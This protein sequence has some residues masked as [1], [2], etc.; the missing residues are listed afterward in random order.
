M[1]DDQSNFISQEDLD[2]AAK[3]TGQIEELRSK[4]GEVNDKAREM[5]RAIGQSS[6][7]TKET[8]T[9]FTSV[10]NKLVDLIDLNNRIGQSYISQ[11][12]INR[13]VL[14]INSDRVRITKLIEI[15]AKEAKLK[16]TDVAS[17]SER[18]LKTNFRRHTDARN[19]LVL[20]ANELKVTE[21]TDLLLKEI[22][23]RLSKG[24]D[25]YTKMYFKSSAIKK[26]LSDIARI[27][28]IGPLLQF[29]AIGDKM[30]KN[31][32]SGIKEILSQSVS[33]M[34]LPAIQFIAVTAALKSLFTA[35]LQMDKSITSLSNNLAIS[36]ES[37]N[38]L[39]DTFRKTSIEGKVLVD[40][41]DKAFLSV[42]NLANG[43]LELQNSLETNAM[44]TE[45]M[46]QGQIMMTKQM[47]MT[48]EEA[49]GIQKFS[50]LTG[51]SSDAILQSAIKQNNAAI[52]YRKILKEVSS[53]SAEL[54]MR[55]ANDPEQIARA[56][57]QANKLGM[58]LEETRKI[59]SSLLNFEQSIEGELESELLLGR[60]F[61][62]EKARELALMGKSSEAAGELL[63]QI[64]GIN[65]LEKLEKMNV[66]QRERVAAAIG[67]SSDELSKAARE[68][69]VLNKLG[70]Q[71][72][73]ALEERYKLLKESNDLAGIA[74]LQQDAAKVAGGEILLQDIA[75][76]NLNQRF[77][78]SVNRIKDAFT[79]MAMT[80]TK[81]MNLIAK[82]LEHT[83]VLKGLLI[84]S[85][86]AMSAMAVSATITSFGAAAAAA[87][88]W[89]AGI[90]AAT[91]G[92]GTFMAV[93]DS[94]TAPGGKTIAMPEGTLLPN[95]KDYIM[96]STTNP[97]AAMG[98]NDNSLVA[99]KLDELIGE[100]RKGGNVYIDST[101]SGTAYG[102]S[103]NSY[104]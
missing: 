52:S 60:Q 20:L 102:M 86:V 7:N 16:E 81:V 59:A 6:D 82:L 42:R 96:T 64:G 83:T 23:T 13:R 62:F 9:L 54:S 32:R 77:E 78:E 70:D 2:R 14:N 5:S 38:V 35:A 95:K 17:I 63:G 19:R 79:E 18:V 47:G 24:N 51:K 55:Y 44:F 8:F 21:E 104:A 97:L 46:I 68:Q 101:R 28:V 57:V 39:F 45:K 85:A 34:K 87:A 48:A 100:V 76:A 69:A 10:K 61:N 99:S 92:V 26:V 66:I 65:A 11:E 43:T 98:G 22:N 27:P 73:A 89:L 88:P 84:A 75:K 49:A 33:L 37:S 58:S 67:L 53:I 56:V 1:A 29:E 90:A 50:L 30:Q 4:L 40:G 74:K 25:D 41:L 71:N 80:L 15:A 91:A 36:K 12:A 103:Y 3:F 72:R 94:F 31:L 93:N